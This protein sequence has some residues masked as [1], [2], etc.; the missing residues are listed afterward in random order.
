MPSETVLRLAS[1][2]IA[3]PGYS[4][5]QSRVAAWWCEQTS[6]WLADIAREHGHSGGWELPL[7]FDSAMLTEDLEI[8]QFVV[9]ILNVAGWC[10]VQLVHTAW[11]ANCAQS[12]GM[13]AHRDNYHP[14]GRTDCVRVWWFPR[15]VGPRDGPIWLA[16]GS[17]HSDLPPDPTSAVP[18]L[19]PA[20]GFVVVAGGLWHWQGPNGTDWPRIMI[21][22]EFARREE[23]R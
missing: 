6:H 2:L 12:T 4:I 18:I 19:V 16:P 8:Q 7:G 20:G 15:A 5:G 1:G 23:V 14:H 3:D 10:E 9:E 21:R 17:Q 11:H 13:A 22:L